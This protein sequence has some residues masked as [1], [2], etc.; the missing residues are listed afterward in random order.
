MITTKLDINTFD[1]ID[2]PEYKISSSIFENPLLFL[3]KMVEHDLPAFNYAVFDNFIDDYFY[4]IENGEY[5][6]NK[7]DLMGNNFI[8][9]VTNTDSYIFNLLEFEFDKV[10]KQADLS[11]ARLVFLYEVDLMVKTLTKVDINKFSDFL[12]NFDCQDIPFAGEIFGELTTPDDNLWQVL[13][14]KAKEV[15][16]FPKPIIYLKKDEELPV[17]KIAGHKTDTC[18]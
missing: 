11:Q 17:I 6:N 18:P 9:I 4:Q 12:K 1:Y 13:A 5:Y 8:G 15:V 16:Q 14:G 2:T 3:S 10:R 7:P